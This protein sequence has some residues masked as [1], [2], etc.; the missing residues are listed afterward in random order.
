MSTTET[1]ALRAI[2]ALQLLPGHVVHCRSHHG[3]R[4]WAP[5]QL[6]REIN[7][8]PNKAQEIIHI[9][10]SWVLQLR[11][12]P[13][14]WPAPNLETHKARVETLA[15]ENRLSASTTALKVMDDIIKGIPQPPQAS[16]EYLAERIA[17]LHPEAN[18][19][20]CVNGYSS[21]CLSTTHSGAG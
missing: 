12:L 1:I 15:A 14:E 13:T 5:I 3:K 17:A 9:A 11:V 7:G 6:L 8:A 20:E 19:K 10:R 18:H 2:A 4:V 21:G 16:P